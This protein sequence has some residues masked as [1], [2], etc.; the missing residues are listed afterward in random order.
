MNFRT[1]KKNW[2]KP[3][4]LALDNNKVTSGGSG[5][6]YPEF[7]SYCSGTALA[8]VDLY[9]VYP[10]YAFIIS[11]GGTGATSSVIAGACS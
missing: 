9:A 2:T 10:Q 1:M 7:L 4:V 3:T 11:A 6:S 5:T 8:V